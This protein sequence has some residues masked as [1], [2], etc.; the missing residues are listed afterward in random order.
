MATVNQVYQIIDQFAP[1]STQMGFDNAGFLVGRGKTPVTKILV[2]LDITLPVVEEARTMGAQLIVAHHPVI[3]NPVKAITDESVTGEILLRLAEYQIAAIC[4]HTNLD[5]AQGGVND[6]LANCLQ[7]EDIK[8]LEVDGTDDQGRDYGIGRVGT[9]HQSG[10]TAQQYA[11][12]VSKQLNARGVRYVQG[13]QAVKKV[14]VGGGSC[15]AMLRQAVKMGCDTFVTGDVKHDVFLEADGLGITLI[16]GGHETTER[17]VCPA[18]CN[19]FREKLEDVEV[20]NTVLGDFA[21]YGL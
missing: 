3:F 15:G 11:E 19:L 1:F 17:V 20:H 4:A 6:C 8:M 5:A 9:A 13:K 2:A 18:L 14:A 21:V 12:F 16:D 10:L 7:L